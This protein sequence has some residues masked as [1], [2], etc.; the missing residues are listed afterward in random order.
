M[1]RK[2]DLN[3]IDSL[4]EEAIEDFA[5]PGGVYAVGSSNE[6]YALKPFGFHTYRKARIVKEDDLF[7]LASLTK[8]C[9]TVPGV[10]RLYEDKLLD[11]EDLVVKYLPQILGNNSYQNKLKSKITVRQLLNHTS[12]FPPDNDIYKL[13]HISIKQKWEALYRTPLAYFPGAKVIYSDVNMLLL[14]KIIEEI[15]NKEFDVFIIEEIFSRIGMD[16]A[17]FNPSEQLKKRIIPTEYSICDDS[18][19]QGT[20]HDENARALGGTTGHAGLFATAQDL[21]KYA[22]MYLNHGKVKDISIFKNQTIKTFVSRDTSIPPGTNRA[23]GWNTA[24]DPSYLI[25]KKFRDEKYLIWNNSELY[26][27][28]NQP[29]AGIFI[30][31]DAIGH[32]GFTGTS[33]WISFKYNIFVI[34]LTNRVFFSRSYTHIDLFNYYRQKISSLIW[35]T[36]GFT[37]RNEIKELIKPRLYHKADFR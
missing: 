37:E 35:S 21:I 23:L 33:I 14:Q 12:G 7:D 10:M 20:V 24:Y 26:E 5:F 25:P 28:Y 11:L 29:S 36:I 6:I 34:F 13:R 32:T 15:A 16:S 19:L 4:L 3:K 2:F 22:Q 17:I 1:E 31:P 8:V 30:D 9:A 27:E 18:L